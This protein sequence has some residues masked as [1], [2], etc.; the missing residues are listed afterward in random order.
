MEFR[1][2]L[3]ARAGLREHARAVGK[4]ISD[5]GSKLPQD[6]PQG[7]FEFIVD[8]YVLIDAE[9]SRGKIFECL[10]I[11]VGVFIPV[12]WQITWSC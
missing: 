4:G 3:R 10:Y 9:I 8:H 1:G 2:T 11:V 12:W 7:F 5:W 6:L